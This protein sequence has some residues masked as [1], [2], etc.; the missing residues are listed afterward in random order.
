MK[1]TTFDA[2]DFFQTPED[3]KE[4][5]QDALETQNNGYVSHVL[6]IIARKQ[7]MTAI[8]HKKR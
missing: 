2:S 3:F 1:I 8:S 5:L 7:E 6:S 4:L